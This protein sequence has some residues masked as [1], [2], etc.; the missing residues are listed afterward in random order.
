MCYLLDMHRFF[1]TRGGMPF[2]GGLPYANYL[3]KKLQKVEKEQKESEA[4]DQEDVF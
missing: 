1:R 3:Y 4:V 2:W